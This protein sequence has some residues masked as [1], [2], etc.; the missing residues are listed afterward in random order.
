M[1][2]IRIKHHPAS[3]EHDSTWSSAS[4]ISR[5]VRELAQRSYRALRSVPTARTWP[6]ADHDH[7]QV[8][9]LR[10]LRE[11]VARLRQKIHARRLDALCPWVDA[12]WKQVDE[13][14]AQAAKRDQP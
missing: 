1:T 6:R 13:G 11:Q 2:E 3:A 14:L 8:A 4:K 7:A 12:L 5:K 10:D 9:E